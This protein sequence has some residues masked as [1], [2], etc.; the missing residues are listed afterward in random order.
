LIA[1]ALNL[2]ADGAETVIAAGKFDAA[3]ITQ[4]AG[5]ARLAANGQLAVPVRRRITPAARHQRQ[6]HRQQ[7]RS[8]E[9]SSLEDMLQKASADGLNESNIPG[10]SR[11]RAPSEVEAPI[12]ADDSRQVP[13]L[14]VEVVTDVR[15]GIGQREADHA[16]APLPAIA[17]GP[18]LSLAG[19]ANGTAAAL[20]SSGSDSGGDVP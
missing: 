14:S 19:T 10:R 17:D 2:K 7:D 1:L 9:P 11:S 12:S 3:A 8:H 5:T 18:T 16:R 6:H 15:G 13:S 4:L 20:G